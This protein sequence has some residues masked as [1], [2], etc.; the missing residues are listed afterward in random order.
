PKA[1]K[2]DTL[3]RPRVHALEERLPP[4]DLL[5]GC[6]VGAGW[7]GAASGTAALAR[8]GVPTAGTPR[9]LPGGLSPSNSSPPLLLPA[10][11]MSAAP[12]PSTPLHYSESVGVL[13]GAQDPLDPLTDPLRGWGGL[14]GPAPKRHFVSPGGA[15]AQTH[16]ED[17]TAAAPVTAP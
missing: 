13:P 1:R 5:L 17:A 16:A 11:G 2:L 10:K 4:G 14:S 8:A 12:S 15:M 9:T 3:F 6:A 7:P